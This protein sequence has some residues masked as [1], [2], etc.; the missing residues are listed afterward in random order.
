M[1]GTGGFVTGFGGFVTM[2]I[3]LPVNV[4]EFYFVATRMTGGDRGAAGV[5]PDPAAHPHRRPAG[6]GR[7]RRGRPDPQGGH[8]LADREAHR[9]GGP[10]AARPGADDGQQG[11]RV[12]AHRDG[13]AVDVRP[14][15][16]RAAVRRWRGQRGVRRLHAEADRR[17]RQGGVPA[18]GRGHRVLRLR[19]RQDRSHPRNNRE[20]AGPRRNRGSVSG[21]WL[22]CGSLPVR[23]R[24][25]AQWV[26]ELENSGVSGRSS[27]RTGEDATWHDTRA[28]WGWPR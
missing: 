5:R 19:R 24:T 22:V 9:H 23:V 27:G 28:A 25:T 13:R 18:A 15:R 12:P 1:A 11:G 21:R 6:A 7:R 17:P 8:R 26:C 2:P 10:P 3:A 20:S 16:S 4:A 14:A